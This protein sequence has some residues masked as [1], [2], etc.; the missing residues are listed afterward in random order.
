MKPGK[1]EMDRQVSDKVDT[2]FRTWKLDEEKKIRQD[3]GRKEKP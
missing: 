2:L 3:A 1:R